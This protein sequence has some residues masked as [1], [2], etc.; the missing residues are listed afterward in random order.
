MLLLT[1]VPQ[2]AAG[3]LKLAAPTAVNANNHSGHEM[4][5][6]FISIKHSEIQDV[7]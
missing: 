7:L 6:T 4:V 3:V 1:E 5:L 2:A